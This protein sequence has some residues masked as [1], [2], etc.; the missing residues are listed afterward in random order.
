MRKFKRCIKTVF[1]LFLF[2]LFLSSCSF[3]FDIRARD[4]SNQDI[5]DIP[6][7]FDLS[8][9]YLHYFESNYSRNLWTRS[10]FSETNVEGWFTG[11]DYDKLK[12]F[13]IHPNFTEDTETG[14]PNE[15][16]QKIPYAVTEK[17]RSW[18][19]KWEMRSR[20]YHE[21]S[22]V[23]EFQEELDNFSYDDDY[24]DV[25]MWLWTQHRCEVECAEEE[26]NTS[27]E[28]I[29]PYTDDGTIFKASQQTNP[30]WYNSGDTVK[31][32]ANPLSFIDASGKFKTFSH[33]NANGAQVS[34]QSPYVEHSLDRP[35]E[36]EAFYNQRNLKAQVNWIDFVTKETLPLEFKYYIYYCPDGSSPE[37]AIENESNRLSNPDPAWT[38]VEYNSIPAGKIILKHDEETD[39]YSHPDYTQFLPGDNY[40]FSA[41]HW[42]KDSLIEDPYFLGEVYEDFTDI[43]LTIKTEYKVVTEQY[44]RH[45]PGWPEEWEQ[46]T[47]KDEEGNVVTDP[48]VTQGD[49]NYFT[50]HEFYEYNA[51][52][53]EFREWELNNTT[54]NKNPQSD[55]IN[56]PKKIT[57]VYN[58]YLEIRASTDT[59]EDLRS[60]IPE[61]SV[62]NDSDKKFYTSNEDG[63]HRQSLN[64]N[65]SIKLTADPVFN[66]TGYQSPFNRLNENKPLKRYLFE[67]WA[68]TY[69]IDP[70]AQVPQTP[71]ELPL[72]MNQPQWP[73]MQ[74]TDQS[75]IYV[76]TNHPSGTEV[77]T[78]LGSSGFSQEDNHR[79]WND[80]GHD[81]S[82]EA[83]HTSEYHT[84][85]GTSHHEVESIKV[86][87]VDKEYIQD[88]ALNK[89]MVSNGQ[90]MHPVFIEVLYSNATSGSGNNI[91]TKPQ[92]RRFI[93][94][95]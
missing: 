80:T 84:A 11:I 81:F 86:N 17:T 74:L 58:P 69:E 10:I 1:I 42:G 38:S 23:R 62:A 47:I 5:Q 51:Y 6:F 54:A 39:Y 55:Y 29:Q 48:W 43:P 28:V 19:Y 36:F 12:S 15:V 72:L 61:L 25:W 64:Y 44:P 95:P 68:G 66:D 89:C 50:P 83:I 35:M 93:F 60:W 21:I 73:V 63:N 30:G 49:Y 16:V 65:T 76:T 45:S 46:I 75:L 24:F 40:R 59:S 32:E 4:Q 37:N 18:F 22:L 79:F 33:F 41:V 34:S 82:F 77:I 90:L 20:H 78:V 57:A 27:I 13:K 94:R 88:E 87:G 67:D 3:D 14:I 2:V 91:F 85:T 8:R 56:F 52:G 26:V 53:W 7:Q 9:R 71:N 70:T 92:R 31:V